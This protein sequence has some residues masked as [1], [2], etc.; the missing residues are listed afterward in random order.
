MQ[1]A[2]LGLPEFSGPELTAI[3]AR[4]KRYRKH[5][6]DGAIRWKAT[7]VTKPRQRLLGGPESS[8]SVPGAA[9]ERILH[10]TVLR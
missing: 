6:S 4:S 1:R 8:C 2:N 9:L 7:S 3:R 10:W 5:G